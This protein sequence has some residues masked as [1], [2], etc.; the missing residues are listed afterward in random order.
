M[1]R[2]REQVDAISWFTDLDAAATPAPWVAVG[3]T[4]DPVT[5]IAA[6]RAGC[7]PWPSGDDRPLDRGL[8]RLVRHGYVARLAGED[9]QIPWCSPDPRAVLWTDSVVVPRSLRQRLRHSGWHTTM[10]AAFDRVIAGCADR[11]QSWITPRMRLAY[12]ELARRGVAH[13]LEV[14]DGERLVGGLYG[15]LTGRVFSGESMYH[16]ERDASKVAA[17]DLCDRLRSAGV[18]LLDTQQETDHMTALGQFPLPRGA[19]VRE[20]W[21]GRDDVVELAGDRRP[22]SRLAPAL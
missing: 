21:A 2:T 18:G 1:H 19:F 5:L 15:V 8:Q 12:T 11:P 13:S 22:V 10:D 9:S 7:F 20:L 14:W 6:Y 16:R 3:G 17:V 4:L